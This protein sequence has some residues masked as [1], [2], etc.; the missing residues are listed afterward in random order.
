MINTRDSLTKEKS[1][2]LVYKD[3]L[4]EMFMK[5]NFSEECILDS[6]LILM[7]ME[8]KRTKNGTMENLLEDSEKTLFS[9]ASFHFSINRLP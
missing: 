7:L 4:M 2:A 3:S 1:M 6:E 9:Y 8:E 5:V